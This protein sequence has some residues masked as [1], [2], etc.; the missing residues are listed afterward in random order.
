[1][2]EVP[3]DDRRVPK[4]EIDWE[5]SLWWWYPLSRAIHPAIRMSSLVVSLLAVVLLIAGWRIGLLLFSPEIPALRSPLGNPIG[6]YGSQLSVWQNLS[7]D[8]LFAIVNATTIKDFAFWT[9][10]IVWASLIL[11]LFGGVLARRSMI[12]LGQ[13]TVAPGSIRFNSLADDGRVFFGLPA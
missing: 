5:R 7:F 2:E 13:R 8:V 6:W 3:F 4:A 9:F 1:M 12:E 11:S 10:E